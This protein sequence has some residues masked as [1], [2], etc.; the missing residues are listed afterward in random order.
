MHIPDGFLS[1]EIWAG[2]WLISLV[3]I[4][5]AVQKTNKH[6]GDK[7]VPLMGVLAAFIFAGQMLNVNLVVFGGTSGHLLGGVLAAVLLGPM[8]ASLVMASIFI[9]QAL[10]FQ[11]GGVTALGANMF[12]MGFIGTILGYYIYTMLKKTIKGD[13]GILLSAAVTA[14]F[15]VVLA[16]FFCAVEI[17]LSGFTP[18]QVAVPLMVTVHLIVG[19]VEAALTFTS[20]AYIMKVRPDLL[21]LNKI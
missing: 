12:N 13:K 8:T 17:S 15:T 20:L 21:K 2:M 11:D 7:Q 5:I 3:I 18:L 14:W 6:L 9:V 19:M 10:I 4:A 16:S 1:T